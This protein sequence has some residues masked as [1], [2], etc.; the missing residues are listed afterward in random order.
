MEK[1]DS[2]FEFSL[3]KKKFGPLSFSVNKWLIPLVVRNSTMIPNFIF[4]YFS[5]LS[6]RGERDTR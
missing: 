5:I 2:N 6:M 4:F 1:I 3:K